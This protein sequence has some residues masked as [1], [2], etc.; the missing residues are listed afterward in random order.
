[1]KYAEDL[2]VPKSKG[3]WLIG[4]LSITSTVGRVVFGKLSDLK[5]VNRLYMYQFSILSIGIITVLCPL[6]R[7]Y[8]GLVSYSLMF[9]FFDGCFVG[10]VAVITADVVGHEKLSQAVGNM[11]GTLAIPMSLGPPLAGWLHEGFGSY[12]E[13]FYVS[14][15]VAIFSSLLIFG[16]DWMGRRHKRIPVTSHREPNCECSSIDKN[17]S[18]K[19]TDDSETELVYKD[20]E[21]QPMLDKE[22]SAHERC[23]IHGF[24]KISD[25]L[26]VVDRETVL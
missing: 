1:V 5:F 10:Q 23:H 21:I 26:Q 9:G 16:V 18:I 7:N 14:G 11:F 25:L 4:F 13:A 15:A 12:K 8:A 24:L 22:C 2:G 17:S 19:S 3:A 20:V 6:A